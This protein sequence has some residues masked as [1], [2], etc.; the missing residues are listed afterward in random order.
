MEEVQA[1]EA[2]QSILPG[3]LG[4]ALGERVSVRRIGLGDDQGYSYGET[5]DG[6]QGLFPSGAVETVCR[7]AVLAFDGDE[8]AG[9]LKLALGD[10]VSVRYRGP[11]EDT[12]NSEW[13]FGST[14][15]RRRFGW[16]PSSVESAHTSQVWLRHRRVGADETGR[17]ATLL[18]LAPD[19]EWMAEAVA[20]APYSGAISCNSRGAKGNGRWSVCR[21]TE[22]KPTVGSRSRTCTRKTPARPG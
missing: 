12:Q 19:G 3:Y 6:R 2:V 14:V 4:L 16:F 13:S 8:Q 5:M 22:V 9:Y 11:A 21:R 15:D 1:K 20:M 10:R 17:D 7:K 18:R